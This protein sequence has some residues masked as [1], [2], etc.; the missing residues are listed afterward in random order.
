MGEIAD[1]I[2]LYIEESGLFEE[3][4]KEIQLSLE[5]Q[6]KRKARI[7]LNKLTIIK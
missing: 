4:V 1:Y 3:K 2:H 6:T 5:E 7:S